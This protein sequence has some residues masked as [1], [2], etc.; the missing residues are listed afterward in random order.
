MFGFAPKPYFAA[1]EGSD[2]PPKVEFNFGT[3]NP[4]P[5]K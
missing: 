4:A 2:V 5:A 3:P 1:K